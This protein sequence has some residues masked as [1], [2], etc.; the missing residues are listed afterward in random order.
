MEEEEQEEENVVLFSFL[1]DYIL[2][3]ILAGHIGIKDDQQNKIWF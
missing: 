3:T 2:L 1:T